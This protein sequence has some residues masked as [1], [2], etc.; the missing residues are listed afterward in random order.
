MQSLP[1]GPERLA[2]IQEANKILTAYMPQKFNVHRIVTW[3]IQPWLLGYRSPLYGNQ[4]WAYVD[5]DD[6]KRPARK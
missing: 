2:L 6:G 1:D 3:L 4:F 5:I